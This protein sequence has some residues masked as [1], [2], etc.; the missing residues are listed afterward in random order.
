MLTRT[1]KA[2]GGLTDNAL[3]VAAEHPTDAPD[4][5]RR[6]AMLTRTV[7]A[8]GGKELDSSTTR[9]ERVVSAGSQLSGDVSGGRVAGG[10][11]HPN[12]RRVAG[13]YGSP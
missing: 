2:P 4:Q 12:S 10:H 7:K 13:S 3:L 11:R 8:P 6:A 5:V 9:V 1:V